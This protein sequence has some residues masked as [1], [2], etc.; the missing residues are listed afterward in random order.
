MVFF[1]LCQVK[2]HEVPRLMICYNEV[3][4]RAVTKYAV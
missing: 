4:K 2:L 1:A 3:E